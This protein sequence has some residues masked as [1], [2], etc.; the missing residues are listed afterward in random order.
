MTPNCIPLNEFDCSH[1][2]N[3]TH[4]YTIIHKMIHKAYKNTLHTTHKHRQ[5]DYTGN[6]SAST[7]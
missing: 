4:I 5:Y 6:Y 2:H 3:N 7:V 1:P